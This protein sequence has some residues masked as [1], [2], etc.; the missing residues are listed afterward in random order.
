[1]KNNMAFEYWN[2]SFSSFNLTAWTR[3]AIERLRH[4]PQDIDYYRGHHDFFK[5]DTITITIS[6]D[7]GDN[8]P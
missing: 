1:M 3:S 2:T 5:V 4:V 8:L 6:N 7:Y